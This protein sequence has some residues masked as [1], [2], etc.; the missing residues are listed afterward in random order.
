V[1]IELDLIGILPETY[2][3]YPGPRRYLLSKVQFS[4]LEQRH[5]SVQ[6]K[7]SMLEPHVSSTLCACESW[8]RVWRE[9]FREIT[10]FKVEK[11]SFCPNRLILLN[12]RNTWISQKKTICIRSRITWEIVFLA[13]LVMFW[14][15]CFLQISDRVVKGLLFPKLAYS[16]ELKKPTCVMKESPGKQES[17]QYFLSVTWVSLGV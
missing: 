9:Y 8:V 7:A 10:I 2:V 5:V 1:R 11:G 13:Y 15:K 3:V 16:V 12:W 4:W 14:K 17:L 6:R